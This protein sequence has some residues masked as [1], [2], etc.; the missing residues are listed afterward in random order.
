MFLYARIIIDNVEMLNDL[1]LIKND[2][3]VLPKDLEEACV[4]TPESSHI[5]V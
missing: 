1:E 5:F 3:K 4:K 2:L